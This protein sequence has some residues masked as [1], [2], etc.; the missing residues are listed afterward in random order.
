VHSLILACLIFGARGKETTLLTP[1]FSHTLG[2]SRASKF[3]LDM[4][5]KRNFK[6][7]DPEGLACEKLRAEDDTTTVMDDHVL[8][9]FGVNSGTG[10]IVFNTGMRSL[11]VYGKA[12]TGDGEFQHPHGIAVHRNGDIYVA[13]TDNNRIVHLFYTREGIQ[14][15]GNITGFSHPYDVA[16]DSRGRVYVAD[17]DN[18]Q[19]VVLDATGAVKAR[20][21]GFDR[22]TAISVMDRDARKNWYTEDIAVVVDGSAQRLTRLNLAGEPQATIAARDMGLASAGFAYCALDYYASVYVTDRLNDQVHK[23][24]HNLVYVTSYGRSGSGEGEFQSPRGIAIGRQFGQL[25]ISEAEGGQYYW[26]GLDAFFVGCFP[27]VMTSDRPGTTIALYS[28]EVSELAISILDKK[29]QRVR[30]LYTPKN[31]E[32]PGEL[33]IVWDGRDDA[34]RPVPAGE[35]TILAVFK[36]T[37]GGFKGRFQK[38][39][40]GKVKRA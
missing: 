11:Q 7:A 29:K 9:L 18:S 35:Y 38:E 15:K 21:D 28:T 26:I 10:E 14:F 13:D 4:Y 19:V 2:F 33:L 12:G 39:V 16:V 31:R 40:Y 8:S 36:P 22:P 24:D 17:T 1:P 20:W 25:F 30:S 34:G 3:Y 5:T 27:P 37:Y 32:K 6:F 23:F